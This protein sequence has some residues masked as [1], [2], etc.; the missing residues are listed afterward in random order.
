[1][2]SIESLQSLRSRLCARSMSC[3]QVW[4]YIHIYMYTYEHSYTPTHTYTYVY[5][6][7]MLLFIGCLYIICLI[8]T[9]S[10]L[11]YYSFLYLHYLMLV[12]TR[13]H[14]RTCADPFIRLLQGNCGCAYVELSLRNC[15]MPCRTC[16]ELVFVVFSSAFSKDVSDTKCIFLCETAVAVPLESGN[17]YSQIIQQPSTEACFFYR[18]QLVKMEA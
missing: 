11:S 16:A 14:A 9:E 13:L 17:R 7:F 6:M 12:F 2:G 15:T 18:L 5:C 3:Q 1:M 8:V 4:M 10:Y